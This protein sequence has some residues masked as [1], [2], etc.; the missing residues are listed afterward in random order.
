MARTERPATEAEAA[1][2]AAETT[3]AAAEQQPSQGQ[4]PVETSARLSTAAAAAEAEAAAEVEPAAR[5]HVRRD[6]GRAALQLPSTAT[7]D[8]IVVTDMTQ[9]EVVP[10]SGYEFVDGKLVRRGGEWAAGT[11]RWLV[12]YDR[13]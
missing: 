1:A 5:G 11:D 6:G 3:D 10:E 4:E 13:G 7:G 2:A 12:E 9:L 8:N